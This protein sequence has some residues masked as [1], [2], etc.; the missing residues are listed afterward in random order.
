MDDILPLSNTTFQSV[1]I[2]LPMICEAHGSFY[3]PTNPSIIKTDDGYAVICRTVNFMHT[4]KK[5]YLLIDPQASETSK[6]R[7]F[8]IEYTKDFHRL[9]QHEIANDNLTII[10]NLPEKLEKFEIEDARIFSTNPIRFISSIYSPDPKNNNFSQVGI[11]FVLNN[12]IDYH[13]EDI[14]VLKGPNLEL[15]EKNWLPFF[16]DGLLHVIY[17]YDP[18]VIYAVDEKNGKTTKCVEY[19]PSLDFSSFRG[20]AGPVPFDDGYL[21]VV[22]EMFL[23]KKKFYFHRFLYL[24]REFNITKISLPF[25]Y[26][27]KGIEFCCG[28]TIDHSGSNLL[29]GVGIEDSEA[30]IVTVDLDTVRSTLQPVDNYQSKE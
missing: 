14:V 10:K 26:R 13:I 1:E 6:T 11:S 7:N 28:M 29:M 4:E 27:H 25:I 8:L 30:L 20:S 15:C 24:D 18:F 21:V 16:Q 2:D 17:Y 22:H 5:M 19:R 9:S 12:S 23:N 3:N